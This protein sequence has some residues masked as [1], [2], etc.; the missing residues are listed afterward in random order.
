MDPD[1]LEFSALRRALRQGK[2]K[3]TQEWVLRENMV[4]H[5]ARVSEAAMEYFERTGIRPWSLVE[6]QEM[7]KDPDL[8]EA[9][10]ICIYCGK[11]CQSVAALEEHEDD[12]G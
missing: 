10:R 12:C 6:A 4:L 7:M 2:S 9:T 8:E 1:K 3:V 11:V 5:E